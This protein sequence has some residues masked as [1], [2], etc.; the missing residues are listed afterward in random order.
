MTYKISGGTITV[1]DVEVGSPFKCDKETQKVIEDCI[2][3]ASTVHEAIK[4]MIERDN[5]DAI[6]W[7]A[8]YGV[9]KIINDSDKLTTVSETPKIGKYKERAA[10]RLKD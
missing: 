5:L 8:C 1:P 6:L 2:W 10:K 4:N 7:L 3:S 9:A